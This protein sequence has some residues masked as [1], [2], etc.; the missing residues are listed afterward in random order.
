MYIKQ[1]AL[2]VFCQVLNLLKTLKKHQAGKNK[3]R[4]K[5]FNRNLIL[6]VFIVAVI[7]A[8][9]FIPC[10]FNGFTNWDDDVVYR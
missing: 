5:R 6:A 9:A 4:S 8:F 3:M 1:Q 2:G 7:T 10:L